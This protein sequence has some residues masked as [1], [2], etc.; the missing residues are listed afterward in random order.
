MPY[1]VY[2]MSASGNCHKVRPVLGLTTQPFEWVEVD[3]FSGATRT[4]EFLAMNPNGKVPVLELP[5]GRCLP[6]SNVIL[7]FLAEASPFLPQNRFARAQVAQWLFFE[8]YSHEPSFAVAL[9]PP[10][11]A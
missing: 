1:R 4:P 7:C 8:Q 2:G 3:L 5:D 10:V 9:H 11:P 6:E